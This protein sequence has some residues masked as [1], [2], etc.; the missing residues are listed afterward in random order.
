[1]RTLIVY[2]VACTLAGLAPFLPPDSTAPQTSVAFPGWPAALAG[3]PLESHA[4]SAREQRFARSLSG[5]IGRFTDGNREIVIRWVT[6]ATRRLHPAADCFKGLGYT[7]RP[8]PL[9]TDADGNHW[10]TIEVARGHDVFRVRERIHDCHGS[11][12]TDV[13][14]WYWAALLGTTEGPWWTITVTDRAD[15]GPPG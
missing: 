14:S 7:V 4:L 5:R 3:R 8:T 6:R 2:L 9:W 11:A 1:M 15:A 13:S 12:W 10:A